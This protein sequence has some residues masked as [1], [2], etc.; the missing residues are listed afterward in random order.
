MPLSPRR[1]R[2][3]RQQPLTG[4]FALAV[5]AAFLLLGCPAG[6]PTTPERPPSTADVHDVP[7]PTEYLEAA[8]RAGLWLDTQERAVEIGRSWVEPT[9]LGDSAAAYPDRVPFHHN[10][11]AGNIGVV[12]YWLERWRHTLNDEA[13]AKARAGAD[14]ILASLPASLPEAPPESTVDAV[15]VAPGDLYGLYTGWGG[16]AWGLEQVHRATGDARYRQGA[17]QLLDQIHQSV[18]LAGTDHSSQA[19][20]GENEGAPLVAWSLVT[21]VLLGNAGIGLLLLWA[22]TTYDRPESRA[23]AAGTGRWL[24]AHAEPRPGGISWPIELGGDLVMPNFSHGAAGNGYFLASLYQ[25]TGEQTFLDGALA[26]SGHLLTIADTGAAM[27]DDA[28]DGETCLIF[29][30][31]GDGEERHYLGFCHGPVGTTRFFERL[32]AVTGDDTWHDWVERGTR[33]LTASGIPEHQTPGYWNN[34][35]QCCGAAGVIDHFVAQYRRTGDRAHLDFA[36]R[37][38]DDLIARATADDSGGLRWIQAEHRVR[39][40]E[41]EAQVGY[42]QGAAGIGIALFHLDAALRDRDLEPLRFV[43]NPWP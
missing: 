42:M 5:L 14:H 26:A 18:D 19:E 2:P 43:D 16:V 11:Y 41:L 32:H 3:A 8:L 34:V 7:T 31:E 20:G 38:A 29:H 1:R 25:A 10:L 30:F 39:P 4:G 17:L 21:D 23:L 33:A 40:D 37:M 22:D 6:E 35:S 15:Q 12:L 27:R 13:L 28:A 24:L 9:D 36:R